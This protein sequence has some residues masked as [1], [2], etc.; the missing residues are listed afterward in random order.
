L[1]FDHDPPI[2]KWFPRAWAM[3]KEKACTRNT[4]IAQ[5]T[6]CR[7]GSGDVVSQTERAY[8]LNM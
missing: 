5:Q 7:R 4:Y 1:I 3:A 2:G 8:N 6:A